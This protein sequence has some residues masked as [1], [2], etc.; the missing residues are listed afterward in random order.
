MRLEFDEFLLRLL[1]HGGI[2][3]GGGVAD[4]VEALELLERIAGEGGGI[5]V[6]LVGPDELAELRAPVAHVVVAD[7]LGAAE[8]Q[9][10]AD[11]LA[12][13]GRAQ[14]ADVHLL[15]GVGRAVVDDHGVPLLRGRRAG[16]ERVAAAVRHEP[17]EQ[18]GGLELEVDETRPGDRDVE[19]RREF[20]E[21][22][23][24][25]IGQGA[26]VL[27][28]A[29]GIGEDAVGLKIAVD[30]IGRPHFRREAG[31]NQACLGSSIG[32]RAIKGGGKIEAKIHPATQRSARNRR[33]RVID[34]RLASGGTGNRLRLCPKHPT[35]DG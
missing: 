22:P 21:L 5:E 6:A 7:D 11:G 29:F 31:L 17:G 32:Q 13:H 23:D 35:Q 16:G 12:D 9:Q 28:M 2:G 1:Q 30:G 26:R 14:V 18:G 8:F 27:T 34:R 3:L 10:A 33:K 24:Q 25:G 19:E 15:G 4:L 20:A